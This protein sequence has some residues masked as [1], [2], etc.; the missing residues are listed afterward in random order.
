[1]LIKLVFITYCFRTRN[2][3]HAYHCRSGLCTSYRSMDTNQTLFFPRLYHL[4]FLDH[5]KRIPDN[6]NDNT[7][8][9][10]TFLHMYFCYVHPFLKVHFP[11]TPCFR[12]CLLAS[13]RHQL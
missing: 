1:M 10:I 3:Y 4:T 6:I 8:E 7:A 5:E 9:R 13:P 2:N 11:D 12:R